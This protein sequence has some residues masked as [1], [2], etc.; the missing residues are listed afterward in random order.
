M[1]LDNALEGNTMTEYITLSTMDLIEKKVSDTLKKVKDG[2]PHTAANDGIYD[3]TKPS[4]W[5]SGFWPGF[6]WNL[7][8]QTGNEEYKK[9]ALYA[10]KKIA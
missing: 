7:Y 10:N 2:L 4:W 8:D 5:T 3:D 6:L 1:D 9:T